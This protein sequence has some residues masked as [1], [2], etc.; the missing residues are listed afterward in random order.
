MIFDWDLWPA[1]VD[2][3]WVD[4][5]A[6]RRSAEMNRRAFEVVRAMNAALP[7]AQELNDYLSAALKH[8]P[9]ARSTARK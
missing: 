3:A 4:A 9:A 6:T 8:Q 5:E 7:S 2:R 1:S